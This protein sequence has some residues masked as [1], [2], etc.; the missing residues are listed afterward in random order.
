MLLDIASAVFQFLMAV[1]KKYIQIKTAQ[2][3]PSKNAGNVT[4]EENFNKSLQQLHGNVNVL[5]IWELEE[6]DSGWRVWLIM[7]IALST[8]YNVMF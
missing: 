6:I 4:F 3:E 2:Q 5:V 7:Y 1:L 8:T